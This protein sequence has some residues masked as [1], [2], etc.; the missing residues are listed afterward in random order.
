MIKDYSRVKDKKPRPK[1]NE[2]VESAKPEKVESPT[3]S[4]EE[5]VPLK[6]A[7]TT[8][9]SKTV[10]SAKKSAPASKKDTPKRGAKVVKDAPEKDLSPGKLLFDKIC[11]ET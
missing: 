1:K 11:T 2:E 5:D 7:K 4:E 3:E 9:S 8:R 10:S 6:P